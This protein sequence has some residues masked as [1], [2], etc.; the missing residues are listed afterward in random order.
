MNEMDSLES[1]YEKI[2]EAMGLESGIAV[3]NEELYHKSIGCKWYGI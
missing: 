3:K 2:H 1:A